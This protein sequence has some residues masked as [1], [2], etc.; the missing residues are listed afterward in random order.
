MEEGGKETPEGEGGMRGAPCGIE[1][2]AAETE[3]GVKNFAL[4]LSI[5]GRE[6]LQNTR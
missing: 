6:R 3:D 5:S 4:P 2:G 1:V